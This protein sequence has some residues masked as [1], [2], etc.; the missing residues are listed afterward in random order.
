MDVADGPGCRAGRQARAAGF[1]VDTGTVRIITYL[2]VLWG[3]AHKLMHRWR[4]ALHLSRGCETR[5][6][7]KQEMLR[8]KTCRKTSGHTAI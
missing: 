4:V 3:K 2:Q 7:V 5:N 1:R 6:A 8:G